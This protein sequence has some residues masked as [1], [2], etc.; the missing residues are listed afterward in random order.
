LVNSV[1]EGVHRLGKDW[2]VDWNASF[3]YTYKNQ[4]DQRILTF[5]TDQGVKDNYYLVLSTE[6]SPEIRN[7]GRVYSFLGEYI[8]GASA[9][10]TKQFN[11]L[12]QTQKLKFGTMNYYRDRKVDV[13]AVGYSV[14]DANRLVIPESKTTTFNNIFSK[15]NVEN[16]NLTVANIE[17]NSTEYKGNATLNAGYV[18]MDNKFSDSWKLTWGARVEKYRQELSARNKPTKVYDNTDVLPSLLL[19]YAVNNKTNIRLAG[20]QAVNRPEFREL[21]DYATYDYDNYVSVRGNPNLVRCLNTNG[22]LRYEWFPAAGE[23]LSASVFYKYFDKPIEQINNGNDVLGYANAEHATTYGIEMEV[24]KKLDFI[25]GSF[26]Q[27]LTF[28]TNAAYIKGSVQFNGLDI[29]SPMQGQS[30][31]LVN[32]GLNYTSPNDG[33]SVNFLYNRIGPRLRF[34][35]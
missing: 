24:R 20:S 13:L 21:A 28:Y 27:Q 8:Y 2:N 10:A 11:W 14:L 4:P 19:T 3:A 6:N 29:N 35:S 16:L 7:A 33:F 1:A 30:P 17:S 32:G 5:H 15:E 22:D 23:I 26:F 34:R 18:M 31:Y 9:N 12:G 25:G